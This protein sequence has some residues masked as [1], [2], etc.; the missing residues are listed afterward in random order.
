MG[1]NCSRRIRLAAPPRRGAAARAR[2]Q[3]RNAAAGPARGRPARGCAQ[4]AASR[5]HVACRRRRALAADLGISRRLVVDAYAQLLAEGYLVARRGRRHVRRRR[6]RRRREP[7]AA[8]RAAPPLRFD[9]FPGYPGPRD[10][11]AAAVAA[12]AARDAPRR[13]GPCARLPRPARR[14]SLCAARSRGTCAACG[15]WSPTPS[16]SWC[17]R[18]PRRRSR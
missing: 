3:Q 15:A 13:P 17:A 8:E 16:R 2:P 5:P 18:V 6:R 7:P 4:R 12:R 9:F 1:T 14:L 11:P 10:V